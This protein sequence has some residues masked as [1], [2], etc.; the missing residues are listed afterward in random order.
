MKTAKQVRR[1]AKQLVRLCLVGGFLDESRVRETV[2]QVLDSKCRRALALL[3]NFQHLVK[4]E[5]AQRSAEVTSATALPS[6]FQTKVVMDLRR[7]YGPG[8]RTSFV[9][10]PS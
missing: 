5:R 2:K 3:S 6:A 8:L 7:M 10:D 9:V 1:E 4:L